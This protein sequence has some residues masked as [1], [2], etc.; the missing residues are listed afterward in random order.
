[1]L[2]MMDCLLRK[3][4]CTRRPDSRRRARPLFETLEDRL[5]PSAVTVY[6]NL[7]NSVTAD[8]AIYLPPDPEVVIKGTLTN[9]AVD[10]YAFTAQRGDRLTVQ[11]G[12]DPFTA[13][14][15]SHSHVAIDL[16][17]YG[18]ESIPGDWSSGIAH[19]VGGDDQAGTSAHASA[20]ASTGGGPV[21]ADASVSAD[22]TATTGTGTL[23]FGAS[24][25]PNQTI[26]TIDATFSAD[27]TANYSGVAAMHLA[28]PDTSGP[29]DWIEKPSV[30][31]NYT[32]H[33][34]PGGD[35][36]PAETLGTLSAHLGLRT[37]NGL[38]GLDQS[39]STLTPMTISASTTGS[40]SFTPD[41]FT[42]HVSIV[43]ATGQ[44]LAGGTD[45]LKFSAPVAG[46]Y[47]VVVSRDGNITPQADESDIGRT[48]VR[49]YTVDL[50]TAVPTDQL[51][52]SRQPPSAVLANDPFAVQVTAL[53]PQGKVDTRYN[54]TATIAV[55][56]SGG[57][58]MVVRPYDA[59]GSPLGGTVT[60]AFKNGIAK[61]TKLLLSDSGDVDSLQVTSG[62]LGPVTT[63][64]VDVEDAG[65][66]VTTPYN[67]N[68]AGAKVFGTY[69]PGA[70]LQTPF[71]ITAANDPQHDIASVKWTVAGG[72]SGTA[73]RAGK[74]QWS[75]KTDVGQLTEGDHALTVTA[76]NA[77]K[78]ALGTYAG[79]IH[80]AK[81]ALG[82]DLQGAYAGATPDEVANLRFVRTIAVSETF[83]GTLAGVPDYYQHAS[84]QVML[85]NAK[86]PGVTLQSAGGSLGFQ[87][88][89][90]GGTLAKGSTPVTALISGVPLSKLSTQ[91]VPPPNLLALDRP[92]WLKD[93]KATWLAGTYTF[94]HA[95][96]ALV[97]LSVPTLKTGIDWVDTKLKTLTTGASLKPDLDV[98]IPL[99][100]HTD[101]TVGI[102]SLTASAQVLGHSIWQNTYGPGDATVTLKLDPLTLEP[103]DLKV[104]L[105]K[106]DLGTATLL[107]KTF[108]VPILPQLTP[109]VTITAGLTLTMTGNVTLN[110]AGVEVSWAG[111]QLAF[112]A[113]GTFID[114]T[115]SATGT[116]TGAATAAVV[117]GWLGKYTASG[118]VK[119]TLAITGRATIGGPATAP[120]LV[121][122]QLIGQLVDGSY[123]YSLTGTPK[124][125][126]TPE[127]EK[128]QPAGTFG[129]VT[130][131]EL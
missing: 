27:I 9:D 92:G 15:G 7:G 114:I 26:G 42:A 88:N 108:S 65:L 101:P 31:A 118:T 3:F 72:K 57:G 50:T 120:Q 70:T 77:A 45:T 83:T 124:E 69:L 29:F 91:A 67:Q 55:A 99:D 28:A 110:G 73:T 44:V 6:G 13:S 102:N 127:D 22:G 20:T 33:V 79:T 82:F 64:P 89:K 68:A 126:D 1:M 116:A 60:A 104:S 121:S 10:Y 81:L 40:W 129:P 85:D 24:S 111:D 51:M 93:A 87:F 109:A 122:K 54:R 56:P 96:P 78:A 75:F 76:Y 63:N 94:D 66:A 12:A 107:S 128:D 48:L 35:S 41:P 37:Y 18:E 21:S 47:Y 71:T 74:D 2:K 39:T 106:Q 61:F 115:V 34:S 8:T 32:T 16:T 119:A 49:P 25:G 86:A 80:V 90:D 23:Q 98:A 36:A 130:L 5:V 14:W 19:A 125:T 95:K 62:S 84:V 117:G 38:F 30:Q 17:G 113:D 100:V 105:G 46:Q 123:D 58:P 43:D 52:I 97:Q 11:I 4:R 103:N 112:V 59:G 53:T 131:F